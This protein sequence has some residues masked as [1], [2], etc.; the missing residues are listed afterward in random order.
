MQPCTVT[1]RYN[2]TGYNT[3][4]LMASDFHFTLHTSTPGKP[5]GCFKI[6]VPAELIC[7]PRASWQMGRRTR[8]ISDLDLPLWLARESKESC[9]VHAS[10]LTTC[11]I[12]LSSR[13]TQQ[14]CAIFLF[15]FALSPLTKQ[16]CLNEV[17]HIG[18]RF[19]SIVT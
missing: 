15:S 6:G 19:V 18:F 5:H 17:Y 1:S 4:I 16:A 9:S 13:R 10:L 11:S 3:N 12:S 8:S 7:N 2:S 14:R